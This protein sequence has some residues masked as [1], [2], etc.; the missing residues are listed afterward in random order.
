MIES[1]DGFTFACKISDLKDSVGQRFY[2]ED[3]DIALF[4][5]NKNIF[6]VSNIC[7]HQ[8]AANIYEGFVENECVVCPM[9]GWTF[10]LEDGNL[11]GG[12]RGLETY[13]T[14][15]VDEKIYIKVEKKKLN[16]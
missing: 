1:V 4:K 7:P 2:L 16:W 5:I 13:K 11:T 14:K 15:I 8:Q 3:V 6:A 9:H 10:K 12:A